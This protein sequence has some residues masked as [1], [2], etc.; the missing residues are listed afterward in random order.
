VGHYD[1]IPDKD[2]HKHI[3]INIE[4]IQYWLGVGAQPSNTVARLLGQAGVIPPPPRGLHK[5]QVKNPDKKAKK[6]A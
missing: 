6:A 4:R 2:G 5:G 3:G 1:P